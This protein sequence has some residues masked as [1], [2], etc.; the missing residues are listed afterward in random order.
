M[1]D[2]PDMESDSFSYCW[3]DIDTSS[4]LI[5][6]EVER[7]ELLAN[8]QTFYGLPSHV[9]DLIRKYKGIEQLYGA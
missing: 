5:L 3:D 4:R 6:D 1:Q 9:E 7:I 2:M 8:K